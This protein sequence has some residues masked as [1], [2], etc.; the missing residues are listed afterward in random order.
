MIINILLVLFAVLLF[1]L[2][3]FIHEFGHFFTAKLSGIRVNEFAIGMGPTLFHFQKGETQYSLR[4]LPIGGY[5]AM[6]GEDES[7]EDDRAFGNK[8]VWRRIVVVCAGAVMNIL[9]GIVLM[10]ILLAQQPMFT[11]TTIAKFAEDS[12]LQKAGIQAGDEFYSID[13]YR[14]R[15]D[16]DL[17]FSLA[18]ANPQS[19][20]IAV[21][22]KGETLTFHDVKMNTRQNGDKQAMV[23]DFYV[24][25]IERNP[26]TLIQKSG[27]DTV[28]VVRMVWYS[29]VGLVTGQFGL[30]DMAGPIGA[31]DAISQAASMGLKQGVLPAMNNII[32]MMMMITVNLGVVNLL[33][34][35]ALDGGRLI[36]LLIE[37][38]RRRPIN[39]KYEGWVHAAGFALLMT[40][41][42]IITY[43]D[44]LRL[45]TGKGLGA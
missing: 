2:I 6:E 15:T 16:R 5:C 44:V 11:S 23:L 30:N 9:F 35:P 32:M 38:V 24:S 13:G 20:D 19:V 34:L 42:V 36:F 14:V 18:T 27:A 7:S 28:S 22:R 41:M 12:A 33:P 26:V 8:P 31:A 1:G 3:I 29:L 40:F 43:S 39:P 37:L 4:L 45:F 25:G 21:V 17:S 10:M